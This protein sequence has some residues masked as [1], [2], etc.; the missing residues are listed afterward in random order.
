MKLME[1]FKKVNFSEYEGKYSEAVN[2]TL[3]TAPESLTVD[4]MRAYLYGYTFTEGY[5]EFEFPNEMSMDYWR[6]SGEGICDFTL[7]VPC[8]DADKMPDD[9]WDTKGN[10]SFDIIDDILKD[11]ED[12]IKSAMDDNYYIDTLQERRI[13][14]AIDSTGDGKSKETALC[15]TCVAQEYEYIRRVYPYC[16]FSVIQQ[17]FSDGVDCLMFEPNPLGVERIYFDISRHFE[18]FTFAKLRKG[19]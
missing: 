7:D 8:F 2:K 17:T 16:L 13:L 12:E 4:D 1:T 11:C 9:V 6:E 18:V 10:A 5:A 14:E 3:A 19:Y 15:V